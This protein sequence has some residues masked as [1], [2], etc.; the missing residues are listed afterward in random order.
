[1][2]TESIKTEK[3]QA[4]S[5]WG[6]R[7]LLLLCAVFL[8]AVAGYCGIEYLLS[9]RRPVSVLSANPRIREDAGK[10]AVSRGPLV[11][12]L[13]EAD[14]GRDLHLLRLGE[15]GPE[16]FETEWKPEKL[17]GIVEITTPGLRESD[18][19]WGDEL[20]SAGREISA[21][22]VRLTWIPYYSWANRDPGEMRVW[23]RR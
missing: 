19:G 21:A 3:Q 11:Y 15:A 10:V 9:L 16:D 2:A 17:G 5:L 4:R 18:A 7:L 1:M 12:C 22:P 14:N 20:Y 23:I 6:T 8:G 13:E